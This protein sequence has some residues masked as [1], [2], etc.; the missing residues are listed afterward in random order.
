MVKSQIVTCA[1]MEEDSSCSYIV[2]GQARPS[3]RGV[4]S[5]VGRGA[6]AYVLK[7]AAVFEKT[8]LIAVDKALSE[9]IAAS[10][11]NTRS[12]AY[13]V[14]SCPSSSF[15]SLASNCFMTISS[16]MLTTNGPNFGTSYGGRRKAGCLPDAWAVLNSLRAPKQQVRC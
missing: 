13:S 3:S 9:P 10:V 8:L 4:Q 2:C 16:K 6:L 12:K 15:H 5:A 7:L 11:S 14:R 1:F